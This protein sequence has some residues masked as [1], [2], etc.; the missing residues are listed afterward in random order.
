M[1]SLSKCESVMVQQFLV[2]NPSGLVSEENALFV[3][4]AVDY[5]CFWSCFIVRKGICCRES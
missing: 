5:S 3:L 2:K 1:N 4:Q